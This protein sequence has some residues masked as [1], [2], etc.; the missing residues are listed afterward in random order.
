MIFDLCVI[1]GGPAGYHAAIRASQLNVKVAVIE[2]AEVGGI[3]L[4]RGCIP[5]KALIEIL[6]LT[7]RL[8][9]FRRIGFNVSGGLNIEAVKSEVKE[10]ISKLTHGLRSVLESYDVTVINGVG[11]PQSPSYVKVQSSSGLMDVECRR[12]I[13]ASGSKTVNPFNTSN[14]L[15]IDSVLLGIDKLPQNIAIIGE[16]VFSV[17]V[18]YIL[19]RLDRN[20]FL[21]NDKPGVLPDM[22]RDVSKGI[23]SWLIR[24]GVKILTGKRFSINEDGRE[25]RFEGGGK[26]AIDAIVSGYRIARIDEIN[27]LGLEFSNQWV[28]VNNKMETNINGVYSA[29]DVTGGKYAHV[30]FMEGIVAAENALGGNISIDLE[31]IPKCIYIGPEASSI[32]LTEEEA[33]LKG[34][35][36]IVGRA[37]FSANGRALTLG[38][39]EG[40]VKV[41]IDSKYGEILGVHIVGPRATDIIG[42]AL[43]ALRLEASSSEIID[44]PHPHPTIIEAIREAVMAAYK[45]AIHIPK[46]KL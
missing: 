42:E 14:V 7:S 45:K 2:D 26:I 9:Y 44:I 33:K 41:V 36:V 13:I 24:N 17:E 23:Q 3:C 10:V 38:E 34:Y 12:L 4:N 22:D 21:V 18:A 37:L 27:A 19:G 28:R 25:I 11:R 5:S 46:A 43:V 40:M 30:A 20:V 35:K 16:D 31:K 8:E 32:G 15:G 1:G 29:G 6:K 39:G